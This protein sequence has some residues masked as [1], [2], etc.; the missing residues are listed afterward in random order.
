MARPRKD[1]NRDIRAVILCEAIAVITESGEQAI[2][3]KS[4]ASAAGVT[5]P[6]LFH[7]FGSREGLIEE[8]QAER[9]REMQL[10]VFIPYR[11]AVYKCTSVD[12][13]K[14]V[15]RQFMKMSVESRTDLRSARVNI[16]GSSTTRPRLAAQLAQAQRESNEVMMQVMEF[17]SSKG[18]IRNDIDFEAYSTWFVGQYTGRYLAEI[19]GKPEMLPKWDDIAF[20][21]M[22]GVL[23]IPV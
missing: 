19:Y 20:R 7:Y 8:S 9:F 13:L 1:E 5:E 17:T 23:G 22:M 16:L 18:W 12:E 4:V 14:E 15:T 10:E 11:D 3:T 21:A 6:T 2:R